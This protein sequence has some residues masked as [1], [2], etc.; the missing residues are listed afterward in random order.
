M[1]RSSLV[2]GCAMLLSAA[3][4][5]TR[6]ARPQEAAK[7]PEPPKAPAVM[8]LGV[9]LDM[10]VP[11][12]PTPF[13]ADA[14]THLVYELHITNLSPWAL[15]IQRVEVLGDS[16]S[17]VTLEGDALSH[18]LYRPGAP[19]QSDA[20]TIGPGLRA[21]AFLW[22]SLD[23]DAPVPA[24][25]RHRVTVGEQ[26]VEGGA[27]AVS[28]AKPIVLGPPLRGSD[29]FATNGPSNYSLHRRALLPV[30]GQAHIAQRFAIDWVQVGPNASRFTGDAKDNKSYRA[31]GNEVL[32]VADAVVSEATDGIP[33]NVPGLTS[34]AVPITLETIGGNHIIL[35][36]GGGRFG[37]YAHLQPGS[38]R[39]KVGD[40]VRRGQVLAL[41]GNSGNSTEPHL[42]F[43]VSDAN[44]PLGSDGVPYVLD[45]FEVLT[46]SHTGIRHNELPQQNAKVRFAP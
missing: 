42:H 17:L 23:T 33:E 37:F 3:G 32:A 7:A 10:E 31:Y 27:T 34:R 12:P 26:S 18:L 28:T 2:L 44:S 39:V 1:K 13:P 46:G 14:K 21:V 40:H 5:L 4:A 22:I 41:L 11:V 8:P 9:P 15:P 25:L 36:L 38:L 6:I 35:D 29:W 24:R 30:N 43:H 19:G 45:S 20:R 16:A